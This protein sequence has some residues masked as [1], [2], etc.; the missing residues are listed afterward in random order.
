MVLV[1]AYHCCIIQAAEFPHPVVGNTP[2]ISAVSSVVDTLGGRAHRSALFVIYC[3]FDE[4][5][6]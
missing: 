2:R 3:Y 6:E 4:F 1:S 5:A